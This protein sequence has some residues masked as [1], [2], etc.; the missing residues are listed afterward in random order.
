MS[1]VISLN[2][3]TTRQACLLWDELTKIGKH[4]SMKRITELER[5]IHH[6]NRVLYQSDTNKV[7][8]GS[9]PTAPLFDISKKGL[10]NSLIT[11]QPV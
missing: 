3:S 1:T 8:I 4:G 11:K 6:C 5:K 10:H 2:K 9:K 7:S